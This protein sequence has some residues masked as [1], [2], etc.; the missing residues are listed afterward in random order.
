VPQADISIPT[1]PHFQTRPFGGKTPKVSHKGDPK[2]EPKGKN[3]LTPIL[4]QFL[5]REKS[6]SQTSIPKATKA[7]FNLGERPLK[8]GPFKEKPNQ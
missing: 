2:W 6:P 4:P 5:G 7:P 8:I 1:H 3:E